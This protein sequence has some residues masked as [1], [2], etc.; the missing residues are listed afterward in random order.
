M[1]KCFECGG[2]GVKPR[3]FHC[4]RCNH[5]WPSKLKNGAKDCPRCNSPYWRTE[6]KR[7]V[8]G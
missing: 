1:V 4:K 3:I 6:R 8:N 2:T 5:Y 7:R